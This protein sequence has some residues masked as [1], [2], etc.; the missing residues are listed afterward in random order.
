M[1][2]KVDAELN[3]EFSLFGLDYLDIFRRIPPHL[4]ILFI[5]SHYDQIVPTAEIFEFYNCYRGSK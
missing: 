1:R 3:L 2:R 4:S 5:F